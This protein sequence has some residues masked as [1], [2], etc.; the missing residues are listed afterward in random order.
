MEEMESGG[1]GPAAAG[2]QEKKLPAKRRGRPPKRKEQRDPQAPKRFRSS[3][4][5]FSMAKMAEMKENGELVGGVGVS[6]ASKKVG[7]LWRQMS[8][9]ERK[10]WDEKAKD[11]KVRYM[12][13]KAVYTGPWK[14][15]KIKD[16]RRP[17]RPMSAFIH[18][19]QVM[20][21]KVREESPDLKTTEI[22]KLLGA[23]WRVATDEEKRPHIEYE[24]RERE[25]YFKELAVWKE[26][27]EREAREEK[28]KRSKFVSEVMK[29]GII[30]DFPPERPG[31]PQPVITL[32]NV[33]MPTAVAMTTNADGTP[34]YESGEWDQNTG[35]ETSAA[36]ADSAGGNAT[37]DNHGEG[38]QEGNVQQQSI[39]PFGGGMYMYPTQGGQYPQY[40]AYPYYMA[41][42][43]YLTQPVMHGLEDTGGE[44]QGE[45]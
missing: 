44:K 27:S 35:T 43:Q 40:P 23:R 28:E 2:R 20:R 13:E 15:K 33:P 17:E 36:A 10:V 41:N 16:S 37:G 4:I 21:P 11:D 32:P 39:H 30:P 29:Q 25:T 38:E 24:K 6:A 18:Y 42:P 9:E 26:I 14:V 7:E 12:A 3:Y 22:T 34:Y 5:H 31:V 45:E 8:K 19:A 1:I